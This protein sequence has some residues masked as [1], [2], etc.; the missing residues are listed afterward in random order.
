VAIDGMGAA[1]VP[2]P[3]YVEAPPFQTNPLKETLTTNSPLVQTREGHILP[4][5]AWT[6]FI[7]KSPV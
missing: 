7:N 3:S 6:D 4:P 5:T 2:L 1:S